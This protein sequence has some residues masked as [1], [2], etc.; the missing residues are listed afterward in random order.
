MSDQDSVALLLEQLADGRMTLAQVAADFAR[1]DWPTGERTP[2]DYDDA[3]EREFLGDP[4]P[5]DPDS[6]ETV[7]S[8]FINGTLTEGQYQALFDARMRAGRE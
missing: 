8:A 1:R 2:A 4:E 6:W 5:A 3:A 7:E